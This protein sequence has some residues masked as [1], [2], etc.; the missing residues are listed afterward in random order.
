MSDFAPELQEELS[1]VWF[2]WEQHITGPCSQSHNFRSVSNYA[3]K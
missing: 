2:A 3:L 1:S